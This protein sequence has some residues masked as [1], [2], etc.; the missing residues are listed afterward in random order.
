MRERNIH[1]LPL[2][3]HQPG[4]WPAAQACALTGNQISDPLVCKQ[5]LNP[6]SHSSWHKD[7]FSISQSGIMNITWT[8]SGHPQNTETEKK[9]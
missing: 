5:L 1:W 7:T 6:L 8:C 3:H 9:I 4:T 2:P